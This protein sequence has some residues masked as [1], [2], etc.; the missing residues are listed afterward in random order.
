[1]AEAAGWEFRAF[2]RDDNTDIMDE[3]LKDGQYQSIPTAVFYTSDH[4]YILHWIERPQKANTEMGQIGELFAGLDRETDRDE[5]RRRYDE[6]QRGDVWG[7]W[8]DATISEIIALLE[9]AVAGD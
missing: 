2:P 4:R 7:S 5:M 6:F 8:R 1:M 9:T 3:F